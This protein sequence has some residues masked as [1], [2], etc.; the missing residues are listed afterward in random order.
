[1]KIEKNVPLTGQ[2]TARQT[3][4]DEMEAGDSVYFDEYK[5]AMR[6]RDHFRYRKLKYA[7]RKQKDGG[8]RVWRLE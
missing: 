3:I 7:T 1:M 2:V 4:A 6:L 8:W 5:E